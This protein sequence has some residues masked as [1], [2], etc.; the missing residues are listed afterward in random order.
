MVK[1][2][3][4]KKINNLIKKIAQEIDLPPV[5]GDE[6]PVAKKSP[7][8]QSPSSL[9]GNLPPGTVNPE[10]R[11]VT[12]SNPDVKKMQ[13][14][15]LNFADV[16]SKTDVTALQGNQEGQLQGNQSRA[17]KPISTE[18]D[19]PNL[20]LNEQVNYMN[21]YNDKEYLGGSDPF[22]N[23]II[24]NYIPKDSYTGKQY[25]N[26]D[27]S[28]NKLRESASMTPQSLRGIID[29]MKRVGTP[30]SSGTEK[31]IDG[32][33]QTRTNN[34]LHVISDLVQAMLNFINDMKKPVKGYSQQELDQYKKLVPNSYTDLKQNE[35][36]NIAKELTTHI[37]KMTVFFKNLIPS[38]FL[39]TQLRQYIDQK[40]SFS[41]YTVLPDD[42]KLFNRNI[43]VNISGK[44]INISL[45][46]LKNKDSFKKLITNYFGQLDP[47][48]EKNTL[49][50]VL[51]E[52]KKQL[53]TQSELAN[54][55]K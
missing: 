20:K 40:A 38:V 39:N 19:D 29:S 23:F 25:L 28:G 36:S 18:V 26:V 32:I 7:L 27:V 55:R 14:A 46:D 48:A 41:K 5:P 31:S 33:W 10:K 4:L 9:L 12:Y 6:K 45:N 22:G 54:E 15:I 52:L 49:K 1:M 37:E 8:W 16:A 51:T 13:L 3:R 30:G 44:Q 34:A 11:F 24:N 17:I 35:I 47:A 50:Y 42:D 43:S 21:T 2:N 53:N